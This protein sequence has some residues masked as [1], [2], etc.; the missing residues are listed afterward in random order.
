MK[1]VTAQSTFNKQQYGS[2]F[3]L[4]SES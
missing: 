1:L 4:C 2:D 3:T